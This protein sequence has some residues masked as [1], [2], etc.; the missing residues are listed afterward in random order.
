MLNVVF[1]LILADVRNFSRVTPHEVEIT[2]LMR[3]NIFSYLDLS[4]GF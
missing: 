3:G 2:E 4:V 1:E